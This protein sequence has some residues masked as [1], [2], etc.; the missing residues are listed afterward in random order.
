[1]VTTRRSQTRL[2]T[3]KH[4]SLNRLLVVSNDKDHLWQALHP[5]STQAPRV[6]THSHRFPR[7]HHLFPSLTQ[8]MKSTIAMRSTTSTS[9]E[10]EKARICS[11]RTWQSTLFP[12]RDPGDRIRVL[13]RLS[14]RDYAGNELLDKYS[15][16]GLND[17]E[18][19]QELSVSARRAA[20]AKM[21]R[22]DR[23]EHAG[24]GQRAARRSRAPRFLD[25]DEPEDEDAMQD[26]LSLMKQRT[27]KQYDERLDVDE[28]DGFEDV[29]NVNLTMK[30]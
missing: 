13:T 17:E 12:C 7:P 4:L 25:S 15:D 24:K 11:L 20:E 10:M 19:F 23:L 8:K 27:R 6:I 9:K 14:S 21:E 5:P 1:M 28:A 2:S 16:T 18:E 3:D 30:C 22:R 29:S 26:E